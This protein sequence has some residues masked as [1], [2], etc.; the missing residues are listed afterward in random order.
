MGSD[1]LLHITGA[2]IRAA[3]ALLRWTAEDLASRSRLGIATIRRAESHDN[4]PPMTTV[5]M[6]SLRR[7]FEQAGIEFIGG[8]GEG[9]G[10]LL[11][12]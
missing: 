5:N 1:D 6:L 9:I 4:V 12:S 7:T 2:Q 8:S 10:V 3:R 11:R